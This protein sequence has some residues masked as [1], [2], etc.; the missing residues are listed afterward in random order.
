VKQVQPNLDR[1]IL[2]DNLILEAW[3]KAPVEVEILIKN[4][5]A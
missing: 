2:K 3:I 1:G 5:V 4:K